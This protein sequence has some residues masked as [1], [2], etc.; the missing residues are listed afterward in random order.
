MSLMPTPVASQSVDPRGDGVIPPSCA[1]TAMRFCRRIAPMLCCL[2]VSCE[3]TVKPSTQARVRVSVLRVI[4]SQEFLEI[5]VRN[6]TAKDIWML[7]PDRS[8]GI[9]HLTSLRNYEFMWGELPG[10]G[11]GPSASHLPFNLPTSDEEDMRTRV[12]VYAYNMWDPTRFT[13]WTRCPSVHIPARGKSNVRMYTPA[14]W[15]V[16]D[17]EASGGLRSVAA[18]VAYGFTPPDYESWFHGPRT[19]P[20]GSTIQWQAIFEWQHLAYSDLAPL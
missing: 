13:E 4:P 7:A 14:S 16:T 18:V 5:E 9:Q 20:L 11:V 1:A 6:D 2:A 8:S 15:V 19:D 3:C 10:L 17:Y 12:V